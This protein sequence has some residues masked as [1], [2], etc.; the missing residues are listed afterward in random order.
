MLTSPL[1]DAI[2]WLEHGFGTRQGPLSQAG[3]ATL[4]QVHSTTA[5]VA[6]QEEGCA[7]EGDALLT[8]RPGVAVSV[9]TA[10]C[11]PILLADIHHQ[12]VAAVHAGWRGT[13][14]GVVLCALEKMRAEFATESGDV[15]AAIGPGIGACCYEV[16]EEV[17]RRF[18]LAQAGRVDL[19]AENVRQLT[20]YGIAAERI[21]VA[22]LCTFCN[23]AQFYSWRRERERA[24]RMISYIRVI[25]S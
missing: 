23:P 22:G 17:A 5:L 24:G 20:H 4:K 25:P 16:G 21:G 3:M 7:G 6:G 14:A 11:L 13:A 8:R 9:R 15:V 19:A 10:D 12:V 1:L 2:P 18:G